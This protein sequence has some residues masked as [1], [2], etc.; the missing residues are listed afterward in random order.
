[1]GTAPDAGV[2]T[3]HGSGSGPDAG[4][5]TI[6]GPGSGVS[7][8]SSLGCTCGRGF[9]PKAQL[10]VVMDVPYLATNGE[11]GRCEIPGVGA[12]ARSELERLGCDPDIY[13]ILFDQ[14][15]LPLYHGRKT[16]RVSPQ[17]WRVLVARDKGCVICGAH[18]NWCQAHHVRYWRLGGPTDIDNLVLLCHAHH[19]WVH[20]NEITLRHGP[21][22][23]YAPTGRPPPGDITGRSARSLAP[24]R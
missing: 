6:H 15:G 18:P 22:G 5:G 11:R 2:G 19:R 10:C 4:V 24:A 8:S 23:W 20:D 16:R 9:G 3:I 21:N 12:I 13:G 7:P 17:Q 1:P 14:Q